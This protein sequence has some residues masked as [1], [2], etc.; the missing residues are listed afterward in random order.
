MEKIIFALIKLPRSSKRLLMLIFDSLAL[1]LII[2]LSFSIR[3]GYWY[4]PELTNSE[5]LVNEEIWVIAGAP[6]IA[7]PIFI[8]FGLYRS[9]VR[10]LGI[11]ALWAVGQAVSMYALIWGWVVFMFGL[12]DIPRSAIL[13]N[14]MLALIVIGGSRIIAR[15]LLST[16]IKPT[17][18]KRKKILI[19][20][21]GNAGRQLSTALSSTNEYLI[22]GF[23]DDSELIQGSQVNGLMVLSSNRIDALIREKNIKEILLAMPSA[24]R[25][26]RNEIIKKLAP[27]SATVRIMP[28]MI[29]LAQGRIKVEDLREIDIV[30]LL[31]REQIPPDQ[32]LL[33]TNITDKVVMV[34]G[35]GG[36]IGSELCRQV[37]LLEPNC[38]ILY[39]ISEHA[40]YQINH[41]LEEINTQ[42]VKCF[43]ALG[44]IRDRDRLT[45]LCKNF[46]VQTIYHAAA[47]KHVPMVEYNNSEGVL[48]NIIGTLVAA[49]VAL[50]TKVETFVFVSTDKAVRP[51]NTMGA[52]KRVAE[53]ILQAFAT[54]KHHTCFTMVRFGNVLD[55]SGSVIPLF[56]KQIK[57]GG[58]VTVTDID[59]VRY[60]MTI[61]EAVELVI[62]AGAMSKGG[63]L[64]VLDM[65][66]PV[67]IDFLARK[68][69]ELSGLKAIDKNCPDGDIRIKYTGLRPGEKL[70]EELLIGQN[71]SE[72]TNPRIMCAREEMLDWKKL[73]PLLY[74]LSRAS[75]GSDYR[76]IRHLLIEILPEFRPN[77]D[78]EQLYYSK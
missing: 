6:L 69:I 67:K 16:S 59:V 73:E 21:A 12:P 31:G 30:D 60:F 13:I 46:G 53:M 18:K 2:L 28:S 3:F 39:D 70:Y 25:S 45:Y 26:R 35:A 43:P 20:G 77:S 78:I 41:E 32:K 14:W 47:Y 24:P 40:L 17:G 15:W 54:R 7:I 9:I 23:I 51:T 29:E 74:Q 11:K 66:E 71:V 58:P 63:D 64:F 62:Q 22:E 37:L 55:S 48:N 42:G 50:E 33:K 5:G 57:A 27:T 56:K 61:H 10:Y 68:M 52:T 19:Y 72:T 49:E 65:G 38:L 1:P 34:T 76:K 8:R 44:S 75:I 4:F 36:S